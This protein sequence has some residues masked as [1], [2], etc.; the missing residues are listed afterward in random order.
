MLPECASCVYIIAFQLAQEDFT[1]LSLL[2]STAHTIWLHIHILQGLV[3]LLVANKSAVDV[4]YIKAALTVPGLP[5]YCFQCIL[6]TWTM[7]P[8]S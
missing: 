6:S 2:T 1:P 3:T 8:Y 7:M 5:V 4:K